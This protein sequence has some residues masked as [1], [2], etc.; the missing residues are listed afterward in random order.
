MLG[1]LGPCLVDAGGDIAVR[2]GGWPIG[3]ATTDGTL[4]LE[5]DNGA[6]ATSGRDRR[7]WTR[8][9]EELHHIIDPATGSPAAGDLLRV[10][11]IAATAT[12]AEVRAKALFIAGSDGAEREANATATPALLVTLDGRT[13]LAGGLA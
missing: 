13:I 12:D 5:L 8:G 6:L 3:L 10:T 2:G 11:A 9:S 7:H 1:E 4:T